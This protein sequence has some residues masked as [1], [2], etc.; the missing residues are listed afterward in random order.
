MR[1]H[2]ALQLKRRGPNPITLAGQHPESSGQL[3]AGRG[4]RSLCPLAVSVFQH[5][6]PT[7]I[8]PQVL[9]FPV[10]SLV[11][12]MVAM[13]LTTLLWWGRADDDH[14]N[15]SCGVNHGDHPLCYTIR[16]VVR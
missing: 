2:V 10:R 1:F 11:A 3:T 16:P 6:I 14:Q 5:A 12:M 4:E 15:E 9:N 13:E 7:H 8:R